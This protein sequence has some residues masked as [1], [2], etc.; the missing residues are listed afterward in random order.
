[1]REIRCKCPSSL[2]K[3]CFVS[4]LIDYLVGPYLAKFGREK[5]V[6]SSLFFV[7][8]EDIVVMFRYIEYISRVLRFNFL[9]YHSIALID[10]E[11]G[12]SKDVQ[13][14]EAFL[15]INHVKNTLQ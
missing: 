6:Y 10:L 15:A 8:R 14:R 2:H 7:Q 12:F 5:C 9:T 1:V 3:V 4:F 11:I 13:T